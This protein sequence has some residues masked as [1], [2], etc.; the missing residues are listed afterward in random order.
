MT[1]HPCTLF[2]YYTHNGSAHA[3]Q[4]GDFVTSWKKTNEPGSTI[5]V[6]PSDDVLIGWAKEVLQMD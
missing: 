1:Q 6:L 5:G 3:N 4:C 2:R